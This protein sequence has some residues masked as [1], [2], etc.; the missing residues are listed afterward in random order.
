MK[1]TK[2]PIVSK[3][4]WLNERR[5]YIGA[6]EV[7][8]LLDMN[9]YQTKYDL[10]MNKITGFEFP[11]N[12]AMRWGSLLEETIGKEWAYRNNRKVRRSNYIYVYDDI[13]SATLDF[14]SEG[15]IVEIKNMSEYSFSKSE[16]IMGV[17][18]IYYPQIQA[19]MLCA[20]I[21][22]AHFVALIANKELY[23]QEVDYN[24]DLA[25]K[26]YNSAKAFLVNHIQKQI[27]PEPSIKEIKPSEL[28]N[29]AITGNL[30]DFQLYEKISVISA[31]IT[32]LEK[33]KK[34]IQEQIKER[35]G[36]KKELLY[37]GDK[38]FWYSTFQSFDSK[39][40]QENHPDLYE[41]YKKT[42]IK[43]NIAR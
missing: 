18:I 1:R 25:E 6:S 4:Q 36:N 15:E 32:E 7:A 13:L 5:N 28:S 9:K 27:P 40:F 39:K 26:I 12:E 42:I 35:L 31:Q 2:I 20:G 11:E 29:D 33:V 37:N 30:E 19:Q 17:P 21:N 8:I 41:E 14:I 23:H 38:L 3:E 16:K 43:L 22:K 24:S 34:S 10:Y